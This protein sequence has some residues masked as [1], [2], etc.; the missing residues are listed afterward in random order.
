MRCAIALAVNFLRKPERRSSA[1]MAGKGFMGR[2]VGFIFVLA[3]SAAD[4]SCTAPRPAPNV[5]DPD[6]QVNIAGIREMVARKDRSKL[7]ALVDQLDS[8]DA[9]VRMYA[10]HA[11]ETFAGQR[12]GYEYYFDEDQ[13][14]PSLA[15]WREWLK[16][17]QGLPQPSP[18]AAASGESEAGPAR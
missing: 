13:R 17:Q 2:R 1:A 8:D 11:L 12:F 4:L 3:L 7:P 9:A 6:P 5:A 15:R 18:G 16:Q 14:K 10:I